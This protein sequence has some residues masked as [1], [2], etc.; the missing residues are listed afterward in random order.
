MGNGTPSGLE[1]ALDLSPRLSAVG[2]SVASGYM[3]GG[4]SQ[5]M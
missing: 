5:V 2:M 4:V 3:L 1:D